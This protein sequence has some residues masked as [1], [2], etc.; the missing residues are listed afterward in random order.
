LPQRQSFQ[1]LTAPGRSAGA[2][3]AL[4]VVFDQNAVEGDIRALLVET[5]VTIVGGPSVE[6][7]YILAVPEERPVA[8]VSRV[9]S[10]SKL[11][12]F[13]EQRY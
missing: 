10:R 12:L 8:D 5:G 4:N 3:A 7:L 13:V 2:R 11:V 1:T 6:G 9:L